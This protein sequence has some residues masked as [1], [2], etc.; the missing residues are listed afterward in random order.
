MPNAIDPTDDRL[1]LI[2][3]GQKPTLFDASYLAVNTGFN[4]LLP[5]IAAGSQALS[6]D[7]ARDPGEFGTLESSANSAILTYTDAAGTQ[8]VFERYTWGDQK[9]EREI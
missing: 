2:F 9:L 3:P 1:M 7:G 5:S 6:Y 4:G 8:Y